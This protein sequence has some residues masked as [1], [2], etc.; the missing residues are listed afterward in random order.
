[1]HFYTPTPVQFLAFSVM[2]H[3][4]LPHKPIRNLSP[5][6]YFCPPDS[7]SFALLALILNLNAT[8][9]VYSSQ[10]STYVCSPLS[11]WLPCN[12]LKCYW[13]WRM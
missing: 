1:V 5:L 4:N 7:F 9:F 10:S 3:H 11:V 6:M 2:G 12:E 8:L 13:Q